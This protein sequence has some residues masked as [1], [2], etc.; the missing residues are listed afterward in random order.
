MEGGNNAPPPFSL[1]DSRPPDRKFEAANGARRILLDGP[2]IMER[3]PS[4]GREYLL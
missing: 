1:I 4:E 2:M 3:E